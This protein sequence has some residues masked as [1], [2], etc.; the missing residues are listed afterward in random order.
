MKSSDAAAVG[1]FVSED[2]VAIREVQHFAYC[3]HRWGLIH[4][5]CDWRENAFV[6][7]AKLMHERVDGGQAAT[8]RGSI[9]ERSVQVYNDAWGLFGVLDAL[10][11]KPSAKGA[12]VSKYAKRFSMTVIEYKPSKPRSGHALFADR[13]QLLAQKI[14]ADHVFETDCAACFFYGDIRKRTS[15]IFEEA[16]RKAL[17]KILLAIA[18]CRAEN[19]IPPPRKSELCSGCSMKDI[20]LPKAGGR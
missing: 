10:E 12:F 6:N 3:P 9:V 20:C 18:E 11:L 16:D 7:R 8:L 5:G 2:A 15:V 14:C 19:S 13:M 4:I 1:A 17:Q